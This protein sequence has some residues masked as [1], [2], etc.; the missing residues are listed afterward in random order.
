MNFFTPK[1]HPHY[2]VFIRHTQKNNSDQTVN[3]ITAPR[4]V[5]YFSNFHH[6][7][8]SLL[9]Y[10]SICEQCKVEISAGLTIMCC[11]CTFSTY[12]YQCLMTAYK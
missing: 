3:R 4:F 9:S 8:F 10:T 1:R 11:D 5:M 2:F 6:V 12:S 7:R